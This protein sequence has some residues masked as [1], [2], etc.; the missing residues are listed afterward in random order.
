MRSRNRLLSAAIVALVANAAAL[1]LCAL[2]F[3]K[4]NVSAGSFIFVLAA[5][6]LL[7]LVLPP[8]VGSLVKEY[9]PAF[10]AAVALG[11]AW[12]VLLIADLLFDG[13]VIEGALTWI[14]STVVFW[15]AG[16]VTAAAMAPRGGSRR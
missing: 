4:F 11:S 8:V 7:S 2:I 3:D 10:T 13:L 6:A 5:L 12:L 1:V 9:A 14:V 15:I 16:M